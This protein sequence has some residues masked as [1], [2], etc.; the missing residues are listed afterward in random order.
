[1]TVDGD[2]DVATV[3]DLLG[4]AVVRTI[5]AAT[6]EEP[7]SAAA[8]SDRCGVS[9]ATVYRR[10]QRLA[11]HG[12]VEARTEPDEDGHHYKVYAATLDRV[13]VDLTADGLVVRVTRRQ[14]M[15]DRFTDFVEGL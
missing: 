5:L 7:L 6:V 15:A 14:R 3:T 12:L 4:D 11:D 9:E 8:L 2:P 10:L 1:M 13:V